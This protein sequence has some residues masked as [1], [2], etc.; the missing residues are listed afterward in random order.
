[1]FGFLEYV[2]SL[3]AFLFLSYAIRFIEG[4]MDSAAWVSVTAIMIKL[5]PEKVATIVSW[6]ETFFGLG[7]TLGIVRDSYYLGNYYVPINGSKPKFRVFIIAKH[8]NFYAK[9]LP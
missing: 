4:A 1:M 7:Y 8:R 9:F 6:T 5:Y 2:D 3:G